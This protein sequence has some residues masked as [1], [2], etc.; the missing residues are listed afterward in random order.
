MIRECYY[1]IK[2][3]IYEF[4]NSEIDFSA[5]LTAFMSH[6]WQFYDDS[7]LWCYSRKAYANAALRHIPKPS[8]QD[9]QGI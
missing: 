7:Q 9:E 5:E 6:N 2:M 1:R 3:K 4:R 8:C